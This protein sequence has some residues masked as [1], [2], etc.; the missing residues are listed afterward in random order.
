MGFEIYNHILQLG[1][2]SISALAGGGQSFSLIDV[3]SLNSTFLQTGGL[4]KFLL[5]KKLKKFICKKIG[6]KVE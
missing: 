3:K 5:L 2:E 6:M 4:V 1:T